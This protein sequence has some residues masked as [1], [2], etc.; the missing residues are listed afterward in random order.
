MTFSL[1][2]G[3]IVVPS[4]ITHTESSNIHPLAHILHTCALISV[5]APFLQFIPAASCNGIPALSMWYPPEHGRAVRKNTGPNKNWP[6]ETHS[7]IYVPGLSTL[8]NLLRI[9]TQ[10]PPSFLYCPRP[11]LHHPSRLT[12]VSLSQTNLSS[13]PLWP[14]GTHPVFPHA[15]TISILSNLLYSLTPFLLQLSYAPLKKN[16]NN[17]SAYSPEWKWKKVPGCT[18]VTIM[19]P[20]HFL[21]ALL[22]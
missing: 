13:I 22:T 7:V 12:S 15:E 9:V 11:P 14:Y 3:E 21:A 19:D 17:Q 2:Q 8:S 5:V 4:Q 10:P 20:K 6:R 18:G 1:H 16:N